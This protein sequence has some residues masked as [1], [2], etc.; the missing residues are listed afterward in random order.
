MKII[1][2]NVFIVAITGTLLLLVAGCGKD[3]FP[4]PEPGSEPTEFIMI[5]LKAEA[6][7]LYQVILK[8]PELD[9]ETTL[10]DGDEMHTWRSID[11]PFKRATYEGKTLSVKMKAR[12]F[13]E[14]TSGPE[15]NKEET[16]FVEICDEN[17]EVIWN[18]YD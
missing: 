1:L 10:P 6:N 9:Y 2:K 18:F 8:I 12:I 16:K 17:S 15:I 14:G 11:F 7:D 5:K 4:E 3:P 13:P